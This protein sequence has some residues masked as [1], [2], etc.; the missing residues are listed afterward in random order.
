MPINQFWI[1]QDNENSLQRALE[2]E[3]YVL[4]FLLAHALVESLL[5][6]FLSVEKKIVSFD[7]LI[8]D[9]QIKMKKEAPGTTSFIQ[10]LR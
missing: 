8:K 1:V 9:F 10:E 6:T 2:R 5:R 3:D 4:A 7:D